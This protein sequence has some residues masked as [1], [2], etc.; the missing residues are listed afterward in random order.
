MHSLRA[1]TDRLSDLDDE[2]IEQV[3]DAIVRGEPDQ[4][5]SRAVLHG[6]PH[7]R[8]DQALRLWRKASAPA[9][10]PPRDAPTI[11]KNWD[12][13]APQS[14][15]L[16]ALAC[17]GRPATLAFHAVAHTGCS[18]QEAV[19]VADWLIQA[20]RGTNQALDP[21]PAPSLEAHVATHPGDH[22]VLRYRRF[23]WLT[24]LWPNRSVEGPFDDPVALADINQAWH[25][26]PSANEG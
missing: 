13:S 19:S 14:N 16:T 26:R 9:G 25:A 5:R 4:A 20:N 12:L 8:V 11:V 24:R 17:E 18:A 1:L 6:W 10:A 23:L 2:S 21:V 3:L 22:Y 7:R 15:E